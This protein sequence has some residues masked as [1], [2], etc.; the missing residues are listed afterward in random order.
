MTHSPLQSRI[1]WL[2]WSLAGLTL[3]AP[4]LVWLAPALV[5]WT[6]L[7]ALPSFGL[8]IWGQ[9]SLR[10]SLSPLPRLTQ[11]IEQA[12]RGQFVQR[13]THLECED[14]IARLCWGVNDLLDRLEVYFQ[15]PTGQ[16][17]TG[18]E[19]LRQQLDQDWSG[20]FG[21]ALEQCR[22]LR[23]ECA[24]QQR[25]HGR[26][27]LLERIQ[28]L[29]STNLLPNLASGRQDLVSVNQEMQAVLDLATTTAHEAEDG[30]ATVG[31]VVAYLHA[32]AERIN[33][34]ADAVARLNAQ[35]QQVTAAVQ[36][37][38]AIANQ[39]NLLALNA[40]IEAARAGEA[41]RGF[42]VVADEV[43]K[44]AESSRR[45]SESIGQVM[46]ELRGESERML[47]DSDTMREMAGQ[48]S[49]VIGEMEE[50][51]AQFAQ[52][53]RETRTHA[54][55]ARDKGFGT[56]VKVDHMIYKQRAY[57]AIV[58]DGRESEHV[59][60]VRVD[61]HGCRL[62]RWYDTNGRDHFG[63]TRAYAS[64]EAPH[65]RVH[66]NVHRLL[67]LLGSGWEAQPELQDAIL[68][69]MR[70]SE[71]ASLQVMREVDRMLVEKHGT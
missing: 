14:E 48:S 63:E 26:Y 37:I 5:P 52:S 16:N 28:M 57:M 2:L 51:F 17:A 35:S 65:A 31:Q 67:P 32:I 56:L 30:Q 25:T 42:A 8:A 64:L 69:A 39:T 15:A 47:E 62:G 61:H 46:G 10:R 40:A 21:Q 50:R 13:I 70:A 7:L 20:D 3:I 43:R 38:T 59:E 23:T 71:E 44:L 34:V 66:E 12:G 49:A 11:V 29:N 24:E 53:A 6:A 41:G 54:M 22:R 60:A 33:H 9:R 18:L 55:S 27:R 45:A 68:Q 58:T 4:V 36:L 19:T 1:S